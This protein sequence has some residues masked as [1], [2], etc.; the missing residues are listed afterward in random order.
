VLWSYDSPA[1]DGLQYPLSPGARGKYGGKIATQHIHGRAGVRRNMSCGHAIISGAAVLL[2]DKGV[3]MKRDISSR[4][5]QRG[6]NL[7]AEKFLDAPATY[8]VEG[9][10]FIVQP[11]FQESGETSL[12][13]LLLNLMRADA[14]SK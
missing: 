7:T 4:S 5:G 6:T 13:A 8:Q 3:L 1:R 12:A 11:V 10:T 14:F 9:R 2:K